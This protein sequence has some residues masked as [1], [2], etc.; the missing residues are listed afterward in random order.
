[1]SEYDPHGLLTVRDAADEV[2]RTPETIRRWVWSG[3]LPA[4]KQGNRLTVRRDDLHRL[5]GASPPSDLAAW[6]AELTSDRARH[7]GAPTR[8]AADLVLSDRRR[9]S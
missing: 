6:V 1:M 4:T 2:A 9:R 7:T 3:R 5:I 8:S